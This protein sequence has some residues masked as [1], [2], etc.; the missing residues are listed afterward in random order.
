MKIWDALKLHFFKRGWFG[1][2]L[3]LLSKQLKHVVAYGD[4]APNMKYVLADTKKIYLLPEV[5]DWL[6]NVTHRVSLFDPKTGA[7]MTIWFMTPEDAIQFRLT[8][9]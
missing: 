5:A 4:E 6:E 7:N 3:V 1:E 2:P 8:F 9:L